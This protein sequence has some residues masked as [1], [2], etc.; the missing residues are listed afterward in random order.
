M[1]HAAQMAAEAAMKE[2]EARERPVQRGEPRSHNL[3]DVENMMDAEQLGFMNSLQS[4]DL[5]QAQ[6]L[7]E[8]N[9]MGL[10]PN[11]G[12]VQS[13]LQMLSQQQEQENMRPEEHYL[14]I[15]QNGMFI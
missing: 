6:L 4:S 13:L 11:D 8:I 9:M 10:D 3:I 7:Q 15:A 5:D 12:N 2:A 14:T 1:M